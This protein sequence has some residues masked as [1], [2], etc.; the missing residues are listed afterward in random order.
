VPV[1]YWV[2]M[3]QSSD[4]AGLILVLSLVMVFFS[5][6]IY[7]PAMIY[8]NELFPTKI[9]STG[10][11][12]C[13]NGGFALGGLMTTLVSLA[14]PKLSDI[15]SRLVIFLVVWYVIT[16]VCVVFKPDPKGRLE[17]SATDTVGGAVAPPAG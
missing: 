7:G 14:S 13:W 8:L 9:R 4:S 5:N 6:A 12:F 2:I 15:P 3:Q 10:T 11:A 1:L 17:G 16:L